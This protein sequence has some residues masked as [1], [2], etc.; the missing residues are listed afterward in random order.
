MKVAV[1]GLGYVGSVSAACFAKLGHQVVGVDVDS[2]KVDAI[3][4][5]SSPIVEKGLDEI[6]RQTVKAGK[7][8][9]TYNP[10][11]AVETSEVALVCVGTPS[12]PHGGV[13]LKYIERVCKE[14]GAALSDRN[15]YYTVSVRSTILPGTIE[16]CGRIIAESSGK[17]E[18]H[19]FAV[20]CN[21]EFLREAVSVAD[22]FD[23]PY[24][25]LGCP[26]AR[27]ERVMRNL[28]RGV[29]AEIVAAPIGVA[30]FMKYINNTWHALKVSFANEI[31]SLCRHFRLDS[32]QVM[33]LFFRDTRL[34]ISEHYLHPGFA[35]GGSCLPKDTRGMARLA[36]ESAVMCPVI[37]G[38]CASNEM[39][40]K[41]AIDIITGLPGKKVAMLGLTFKP[42]TDD[43]RESPY[44]EVAER[45]IGKGYRLSIFDSNLQLDKLVGQ[46]KAFVE[47][48]L[49]HL[50]ALL[51][52]SAE[53]VL[54]CAEIVVAGT[55]ARAIEPLLGALSTDVAIVDLV[56]LGDKFLTRRNYYGIC[57]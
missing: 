35:Y 13:D 9:A 40:I 19:D 2:Q 21:P 1:F 18:F 52:P 28:Y 37:Q 48:H 20:C 23:P 15:N 57:W 55:S 49:P 51:K 6:I 3:N 36:V 47:K 16:R 24:I 12:L 4:N 32:H 7:L 54:Q 50:V 43:L 38:I 46:N 25:L 10:T 11:E 14:I 22:F 17:S 30:E 31:G 8:R 27:S 44:L 42:G 33:N 53:D 26:N 39:H 56:R 41:R 45:L 34:N 29:D 5:G